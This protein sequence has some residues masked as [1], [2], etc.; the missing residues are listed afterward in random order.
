MTPRIL[1]TLTAALAVLLLALLGA[2]AVAQD[3]SLQKAQAAFDKAQLEYQQGNYDAAAEAFKAAYD[4]RPFPQFLYNI[5]AAFHMKGKKNSDLAAYAKAVEYYKRYLAED[6][7][8]G[9]RA[10]VEKSIAVLD[11]EI[12]R[13]KTAPAPTAEQPA[14][15]SAEVQQ[16]GDA[17]VRGLMVIESEP[18][19]ASIYLDKKDGT[20][21]AKTPWSGSLD[22][23]HTIIVEKRGYKSEETRIAPDPS[24]LVVIRFVLAEEDYLGWVDIKSN[25]P[26][27]DVFLDD[28]SVGAIGKTPF[29]GNLKPGRHTV[30]VSV[31]GYEEFSQEIEVIAGET[32]EVNAN[33]SGAPVGYLNLRGAGIERSE[34]IVDGKVL[35]ER[36][37]CRKPVPEG[38]HTITIRRPGYRPF[39]TRVE[40]QAR[41]EVSVSAQL[42][43]KP[44]RGDAVGAYVVSALF[45]GGGAY[46]GLQARK[47]EDDL[48][49]EIAAGDP[50][51][52]SEDPRLLRGKLFAIGA[53]AAFGVSGIVALTAIYYTFR[54]KGAPSTGTIDVQTLALQ[55]R[56]GSDYAGMD[57]E[58]RW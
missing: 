27:A 52:D 19:G 12:A 45:A 51:P 37:P 8:A 40:V 1:H 28:K 58:V 17:S 16:L 11:A 3:A 36:G 42:T 18:Q 7:E 4:A 57:L 32:L 33:L 14:A 6:P 22:G 26:G 41:T 9:D 43:R 24:R 31:D 39:T 10:R 13:L 21:L 48:R 2:P 34:I 56:I 49:A 29:S 23:E 20:V 50:P 25:V 55:P 54:E 44:G 5:G 15:P 35:C 47:I 30:Y 53:N 38:Y 46:L